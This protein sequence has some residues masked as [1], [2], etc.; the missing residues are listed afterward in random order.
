MIKTPATLSTLLTLCLALLGGCDGDAPEGADVD[1]R[2]VTI[3][4]GWDIYGPVSLPDVNSCE[5][6]WNDRCAGLSAAQCKVAHN[7]Y[8]CVE[9]DLGVEIR[10]SFWADAAAVVWEGVDVDGGS[11]GGAADPHGACAG[12][13]GDPEACEQLAELAAFV[14]E[15]LDVLADSAPEGGLGRLRAGEGGVTIDGALDLEGGDLV[16]GTADALAWGAP[17]LGKAAL[18]G[19]YVFEDDVILAIRPNGTISLSTGA[20]AILGRASGSCCEESSE[21][22]VLQHELILPVY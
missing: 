1:V 5:D 22:P 18:G 7:R 10:D 20:L 12:L 16:L 3:T 2:A 17:L 11:A 14:V 19:G 6:Y 4:D 8:T 15:N 13:G 21:E 9:S